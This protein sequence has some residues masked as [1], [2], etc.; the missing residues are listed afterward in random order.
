MHASLA[1]GPID[2]DGRPSRELCSLERPRSTGRSIGQID[3]SLYPG[4]GRSG[5]SIEAPTV[6][7]LTVG[8]RP[9]T[10]WAVN[11][12]QRLVFLAYKKGGLYGLFSIRFLVGFGASFSYSFKRFSP[13]VLEPNTSIQ[14][15]N[16]SRVFKSDFLVFFTTNSILVFLTNTCAIH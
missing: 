3:C 7:N 4:H 8:G 13:L 1:E 5:R 10:V 15:K 14:K 9:T 6:R 2:R 12:P 11:F 16:L